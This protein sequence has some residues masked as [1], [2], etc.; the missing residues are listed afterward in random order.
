MGRL[1]SGPSAVAA[2]WAAASPWAVWLHGFRQP[3]GHTGASAPWP[4]AWPRHMAATNPW[5]AVEPMGRG[6][7]HG[8]A[9]GC[10][11]RMGCRH[12]MGCPL[13]PMSTGH[14]MG[15]RQPMRPERPTGC[16]HPMAASWAAATLCY[17]APAPVR[18]PTARPHGRPRDRS[19]RRFGQF[20]R[21]CTP[22]VPARA[23]GLDEL[24]RL[25]IVV[26]STER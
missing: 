26:E 22:D 20:G 4:P 11:H 15:R 18:C 5:A 19:A 7:T 12:P 16:C 1:H 14:P 2:A 25:R 9:M 13:R 8:A 21:K 17:A 23:A 6:T 10:G 24:F 3:C